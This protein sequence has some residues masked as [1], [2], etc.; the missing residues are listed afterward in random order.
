M[1]FDFNIVLWCSCLSLTPD[2]ELN[3]IVYGYILNVNHQQH[4]Q[5]VMVRDDSNTAVY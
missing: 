4:G 3:R 5:S 1:V 2:I